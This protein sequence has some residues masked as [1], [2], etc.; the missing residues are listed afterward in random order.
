M[1]QS[2]KS[3]NRTGIILILSLSISFVSLAQESYYGQDNWPGKTGEV[4][5]KLE[6]P[7]LFITKYDL[8]LANGHTD[9]S[10]FFRLPIE[11]D[12]DVK[13]GRL[14]ISIYPSVEESQSALVEYLDCLTTINKPTRLQDSEIQSVDVAFG[15]INEGIWFIAFT[16]NNIFI[17]LK[18][19]SETIKTLMQDIESVIRNAPGIGQ[20]TDVPFISLID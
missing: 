10:A 7:K 13:K 8:T 16:K 5:A 11:S 18:A 12:E 20:A 3:K 15:N 17:I 2:H 1:M 9:Y 4:K 6:I 19:S 14:Q